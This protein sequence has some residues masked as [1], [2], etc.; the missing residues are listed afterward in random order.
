MDFLQGLNPQQQA[1]VAHVEGP[2]LLLAGAGSGK[3]RVITHRIAHLVE[4][5]RVPGP[6]IIA[7]T[8]T[9]KAAEEMRQRVS[10]LLGGV[11]S[12]ESPLVSTFHSFCVRV[13][14]RDGARLADIR[15]GFTPKFTIYDADDQVS[16][17]KSIFK[18]SGLNEEFMQYR[19]AC[20]WISHKKSR[21]ESPEDV[22]GASTDA[23]TSRLAS[24]YQQYEG[25]LRQANALDFDDLLLECV[26][27][28]AQDHELRLE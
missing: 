16:L 4:A 20:S 1:A 5:H 10:H 11:H 22:Y 24:I 23:H 26:R 25:R 17:V 14:R 13:L 21:K 27:L 12:R 15:T 18:A 8:F 7:V 6:C 3:T 28:L 19:A 9:N 2:L